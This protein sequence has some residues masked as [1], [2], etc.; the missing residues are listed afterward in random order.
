MDREHNPSRDRLPL[1]SSRDQNCRWRPFERFGRW[2]ASSKPHPFAKKNSLS[3]P[4]TSCSCKAASHLGL[5][6]LLRLPLRPSHFQISAPTLTKLAPSCPSS[7]DLI[8]LS[9]LQPQLLTHLEAKPKVKALGTS[10]VHQRSQRH[11]SPLSHS[12]Q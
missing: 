11:N 3:S 12:S 8:Y 4:P 2:P 5:A 1:L 6:L 10:E 9:R 7:K